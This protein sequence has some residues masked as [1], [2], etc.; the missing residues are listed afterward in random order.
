MKTL[1]FRPAL[2]KPILKGKTKTTWRLFDEKIIKKNEKVAL[3]NWVT[4]KEFAK[5]RVIGVRKTTFGKLKEE[6][7]EN[8]EDYFD[9]KSMYK[10][11][12]KFYK[13]KVDEKTPLKIIK[14]E[15]IKL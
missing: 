14:F 3:V 15:L 11:Y 13:K 9:K 2:I 12:T 1:K 6:D 5:A 7:F 10:R 4:K 8:H